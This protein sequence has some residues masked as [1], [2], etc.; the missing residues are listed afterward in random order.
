MGPA[1]GRDPQSSG[2]DAPRGSR[3]RRGQ[4]R[5]PCAALSARGGVERAGRGGSADSGFRGAAPD[6]AGTAGSR[7]APGCRASRG[8]RARRGHW[9]GTKARS[10]ETSR[11]EVAGAAPREGPPDYRSRTAGSGP[12]KRAPRRRGSMIWSAEKGR[13]LNFCNSRPLGS[14]ESTGTPAGV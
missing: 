7:A 8:G 3:G 14:Q 13:L 10:E 1:A 5:S 9:A 4:V 2:A 6:A 12:D 11:C